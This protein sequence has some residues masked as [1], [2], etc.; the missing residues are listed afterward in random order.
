MQANNCKLWSSHIV[1]F[2]VGGVFFF[3]ILVMEVG[4]VGSIQKES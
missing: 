1:P 4:E 3:L 2:Q